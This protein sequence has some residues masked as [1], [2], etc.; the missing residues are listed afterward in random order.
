MKILS[1]LLIVLGLGVSP[2]AAQEIYRV[3][4]EHGN[5]TYTDQ[6]PSDD[7]EPMKL[8]ELNVLQGEEEE[9]LPIE[10]GN[11]EVESRPLEFG[12][13]TPQDGGVISTADGS[14][15]V[16]V[17]INIDVPPTAELVIF[18]NG[19]PQEPVHTLELT[20]DEVPPGDHELRA[21]LQTPAG[22]AIA[23]TDPIR[24]E[25]RELGANWQEQ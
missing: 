11:G 7:A 9:T 13:E 1:I 19:Q 2:L 8:P 10:P 6:K 20:L 16:R 24:F 17:S 3:V 18:F 25:V 5:V 21:V 12:F 22:R 15:P 23:S 4:D 14:V